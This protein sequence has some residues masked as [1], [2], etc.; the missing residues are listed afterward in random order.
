MSTDKID[1][2]LNYWFDSIDD[3]TAID[4]N[5]LPFK[6]WFTKDTKTD[7]EI[8]RWFEEDLIKAAGGEYKDW[9]DSPQGRLAL[10]LLYDQFSRNMYRETEKMYAYDVL[11]L[12]LTLRTINQAKEQD[13]TLIRRAF[14]YMPLMHSEDPEIQQL[15]VEYFNKLVE[16]SKIE[17]PAN[18]HYYEYTLK[19]AQEHCNT[20][21]QF[22]RFP[23]RDA[24]L[25]R[26]AQ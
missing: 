21:T 26:I 11:A 8:R 9:E 14:L 7:E 18:T 2:I 13:L 20:V 19:Y 3:S 10:I 12:E 4:K 24:I 5:T 17:I 16:E 23:Y 6:K 15:S 25:K 22:G 1:I